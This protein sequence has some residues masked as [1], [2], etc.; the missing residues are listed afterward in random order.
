MMYSDQELKLCMAIDRIVQVRDA[1]GDEYNQLLVRAINLI[2]CAIGN[3][4]GGMH[5]DDLREFIEEFT[6]LTMDEIKEIDDGDDSFA[7][8][9]C[10]SNPIKCPYAIHRT[11]T[12]CEGFYIPEAIKDG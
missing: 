12:F 7:C 1:L 3:N 9:R 11:D 10:V 2:H 8:Y 5:E 6:G 4:E